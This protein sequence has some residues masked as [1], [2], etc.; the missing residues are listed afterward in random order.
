MFI[1][2]YDRGYSEW[3]VACVPCPDGESGSTIWQFLVV[4]E[5]FLYI[6]AI[7]ILSQGLYVCF[8]RSFGNSVSECVVE[9]FLSILYDRSFCCWNSFLVSIFE[10]RSNRFLSGEFS[11]IRVILCKY[12]TRRQRS[13]D[14]LSG[15]FLSSPICSN[16]YL[17][18]LNER[19]GEIPLPLFLPFSFSWMELFFPAWL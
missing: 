3:G 14:G 7:H 16:I 2:G 15:F 6:L 12:S 9:M 5:L 13:G 10:H 17:F 4:F 19:N 18:D 11:S 1:L 8:L